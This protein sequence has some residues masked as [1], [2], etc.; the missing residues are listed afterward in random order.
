MMSLRS[1]AEAVV[2]HWINGNETQ[3]VEVIFDLTVE[4]SAAVAAYAVIEF[5]NLGYG[6]HPFVMYLLND[7]KQ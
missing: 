5:E 7:A 2:Q 6:P 4:E 1:I 3:A